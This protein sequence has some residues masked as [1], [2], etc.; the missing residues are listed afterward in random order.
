MY[1]R[2]ELKQNAKNALKGKWGSAILAT[3]IFVGISFTVAFVLKLIENFV[4]IGTL[5]VSKN[6][7]IVP[8]VSLI[9]SIITS[10][11]EILVIAPMTIGLYSYFLNLS[12]E[13]KPSVEIIFDGFKKSFSNS[14]I[15][16][17]LIT[18]YTF[19]WTLLFII[20]GIIKAYSYSMAF[21]IMA[22][23]PSISA[24]EAIKESMRI[25]NGHKM[26]LFFLQL[27][28]IGW[29]ILA[30]FTCG[31]GFLWLVPYMNKT[32]ANFYQ[33]IKQDNV[34]TVQY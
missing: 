18:V 19:L 14:V 9:V 17:I 1:T 8:L 24:G 20:P 29:A 12:E 28:F 3:I 5:L 16:N 26:E 2:A 30:M 10:I 15:M 13:N 22:E 34:A 27:S 7:E 31:I 25:M 11:L 23:N 32:T 4:G 6:I 21:Y 33:S